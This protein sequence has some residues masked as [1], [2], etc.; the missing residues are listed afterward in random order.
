[1]GVHIDAQEAVE[2]LGK[3]GTRA[4]PRLHHVRFPRD[5]SL[6]ITW[7]PG[8]IPVSGEFLKTRGYYPTNVLGGWRG[9]GWG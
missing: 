3:D 1:V 8:D 7:V 9:R 4:A 5:V 6:Y 2:G